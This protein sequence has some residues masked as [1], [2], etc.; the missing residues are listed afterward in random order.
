MT[1]ALADN[2]L[3]SSIVAI[4]ECMESSLRGGGKIL[5]AGNGG[6]AADAQHFAGELLSR[7]YFDRAPLPA[8]ALTT[9]SS[10]LTAIG[11]DYGFED[12]FSRQ[13]AGLGREGDV[14]V[15]ISTSGKSPNIL[16]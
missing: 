15:A 7:L 1:N 6:S 10:V 2:A 8:I 14:F 16:T 4:A 11:N 9:D 3:V 13:V 12:V 5:L